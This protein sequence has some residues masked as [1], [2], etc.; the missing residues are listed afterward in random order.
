LV[1]NF[2]S[3]YKFKFS[4]EYQIKLASYFENYNNEKILKHSII[5][6]AKIDIK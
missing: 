5:E 6:L 2:F 4:E 3:I 1:L